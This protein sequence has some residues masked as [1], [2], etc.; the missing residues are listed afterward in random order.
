[1]GESKALLD[2]DGQ[3]FLACVVACLRRGGC[4]SVLVVVRDTSDPVGVL[5]H[6]LGARVVLNPDPSD[7]PISSVRAALQALH[8]SERSVDAI[9]IC[10]VDHPTIRAE[11]VSA[12]ISA[13]AEER[14]PIVVPTYEARSGHPILFDQAL[15]GELLEP[16]LPE[17]A[18]TVTAR[19]RTSLLGVPVPD[20]GIRLDL[21]TPADYERHFGRAPARAVGVS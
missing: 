16:S 7:G 21:D 14:A 9:A 1:M 18:R 10:P 13:Y 15:F 17:G 3:S 20:A 19:H 6:T 2:A 8:T 5:A 11:T 4:A 12:L